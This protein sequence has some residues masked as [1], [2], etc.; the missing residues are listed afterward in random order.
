MGILCL[1][2]TCCFKLIIRTRP[3][4]AANETVIEKKQSEGLWRHLPPPRTARG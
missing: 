1:F 2:F 3:R 4:T